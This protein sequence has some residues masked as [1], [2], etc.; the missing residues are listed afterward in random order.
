M[1][2]QSNI[3]RP[4]LCAELENHVE[5]KTAM[6]AKIWNMIILEGKITWYDFSV[7]WNIGKHIQTPYEHHHLQIT[8][9][10]SI[11][12]DSNPGFKLKMFE[13]CLS[14]TLSFSFKTLQIYSK[15]K[16][17]ISIFWWCRIH[18]FMTAFIGPAYLNSLTGKCGSISKCIIFKLIIQNSCLVTHCEIA[19]RGMLQNLTNKKSLL[20]QV[21]TWCHQT[22][23]HYLNQ[24]YPPDNKPLFEPMLTHIYVTILVQLGHSEAEWRIYASVN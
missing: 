12:Y 10:L 1:N 2:H 8:N 14:T 4:M 18:F 16:I 24:C 13:T 5:G 23:S 17:S 9:V 7:A 15:W 22:T 11:E 19:L 6:P 20:V 3:S 21:I